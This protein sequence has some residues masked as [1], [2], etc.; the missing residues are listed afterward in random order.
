[1]AWA[2][3]KNLSLGQLSKP[4]SR[5]I[6]NWAALKEPA[7]CPLRISFA[8]FLICEE[9]RSRAA[10]SPVR[11]ARIKSFACLRNWL[12]DGFVGSCL[13]VTLDLLFVHA[14]RPLKQAEKKV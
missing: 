2:S 7:V 1:M 4:Y 6:V 14:R 5:A 11:K 3:T 13:V 12:R 10:E 8:R 9:I